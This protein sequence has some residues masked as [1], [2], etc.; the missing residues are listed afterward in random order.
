MPLQLSPAYLTHYYLFLMEVA[1]AAAPPASGGLQW[2]TASD[3]LRGAKEAR[4]IDCGL[5]EGAEPQ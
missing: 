2:C 3:G 1:L 4:R 5:N